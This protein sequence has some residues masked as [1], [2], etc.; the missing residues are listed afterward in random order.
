MRGEAVA[1]PLAGIVDLAAERRASTRKSRGIQQEIAKVQAKLGNPD[2][3]ARAPEDIIAEHEDRLE[4]FQARF[5]KLNAARE[6]LER[7]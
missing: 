3:V 4:T 1:L 6:R 2:F 7:V 5:V